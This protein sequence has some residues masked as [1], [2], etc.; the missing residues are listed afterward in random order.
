MGGSLAF[1]LTGGNGGDSTWLVD[2]LQSKVTNAAWAAD[3]ADC[4][5]TLSEETFLALVAGTIT[6][7]QALPPPQ[8]PPAPSQLGHRVR[9]KCPQ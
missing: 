9:E 2:C 5:V 8:P 6:G 7:M 3:G 4:T 1:V